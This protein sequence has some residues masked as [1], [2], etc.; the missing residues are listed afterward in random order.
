MRCKDCKHWGTGQRQR[1]WDIEH[2]DYS[3]TNAEDIG[4]APAQRICSAVTL[5]QDGAS[6]WSDGPVEERRVRLAYLIDA[7]SY[8]ADMWTAPTFGCALFE[9]ARPAPPATP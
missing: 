4:P 3:V 1:Q 7:S 9:P 6:H 5:L 2:A 8:R